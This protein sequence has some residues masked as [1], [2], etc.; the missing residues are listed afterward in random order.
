MGGGIMKSV[1]VVAVA[2]MLSETLFVEPAAAAACD[3]DSVQSGPICIDKFESSVWY[4]P[5]SEKGLIAKIQNGHASLA[6]LTSAS[7]LAA[8]V[9]QLGLAAGDLAAHACPVT[10]N[11]CLDFYAV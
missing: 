1:I 4:V 10:G 7:A 2:L 9:V 8:G 3:P 5:P 11:G 6:N